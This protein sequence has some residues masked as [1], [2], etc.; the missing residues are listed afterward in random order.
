M[1][2]GLG[3]PDSLFGVAWP[4]IY[5][6]FGDSISS[7]SYVTLLIS[8]GTVVSSLISAKLIN[9]FGTALVTAVSTA[10]TA[11][12][13]WG[14][15]ISSSIFY[16]C[17]FAIPLGLGAGAVDTALNNYVALRYKAK[18]MDFLHCFYGIGVSMSPY[19]MSLALQNSTWQTGYKNAALFQAVLAALAIISIPIWGK[20]SAKVQVEK[21][22]TKTL[23]VSEMLKMPNVRYTC[24]VFFSYCALEVTCGTWSSSFLVNSRGVSAGDA[25]RYI[26]FYYAGMALGRFASGLL[27]NKLTSWNVIKLGQATMLVG[28]CMILFKLPILVTVVGLFLAGFGAGPI[29][30]NLLHLTPIHFGTKISQSVMGVEMALS[31]IGIMSMPVLFSIIAQVFSTDCFPL[32]LL[33]MFAVMLSSTVLLSNGIQKSDKTEFSP[34]A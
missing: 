10:M 27:A 5:P 24:L 7:A 1:F 32:F 13:L 15:S 20:V 31:Y 33:C 11:I 28:I 17:L 18:H 30:P 2:I 26:M 8:G 25:A 16:L 21:I 3:I 14:F 23:R 22:A 12:A 19:I 29:F 6:E 4:A 34:K 9:R